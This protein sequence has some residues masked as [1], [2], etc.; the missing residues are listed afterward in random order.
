MNLW[1]AEFEPIKQLADKCSLQPWAVAGTGA[2]WFAFMLLGFTGEFICKVLGCLYPAYASF[3]VLEDDDSAQVSQWLMYWVVF[4]SVML[5]DSLFSAM[6]SLVPFYYILRLVL[7]IWLFSPAT[8]GAANAYRWLIGPILRKYRSSI[9]VA[10]DRSAEELRGT[11]IGE[12]KKTLGDAR[13]RQEFGIQEMVAQE[14]AKGA[15]AGLRKVAAAGAISLL[16]HRPAVVKVGARRRVASPALVVHRA[17]AAH[18]QEEQETD[19]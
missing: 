16:E 2:F 12:R 11:L 3:R 17:D 1:L 9:D 6:W 13:A 10:L 7:I 15:A 18:L 4:A 14:L 5:T 19:E 8:F